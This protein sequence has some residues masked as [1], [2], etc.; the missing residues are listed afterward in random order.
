[1]PQDYQHY[2]SLF[3]DL[4]M[5]L[6]FV[7]LDLLDRNIEAVLQRGKNKQIRV[8][9]KSVRSTYILKHI[10]EYSPRFIGI[11]SYTGHE[12]VF[13]AKKGFDNL[14]VAYPVSHPQEI[15]AV[16]E[17]IQ[18]GSNIYLM[19][20]SQEHVNRIQL[21][22]KE[23]G[24]E[25][26]VCMDVDM[27]T[28]HFG[29][30]FG[31]YRSPIRSVEQA[32]E[33]ADYISKQSSVVLKGV[34]GYEAQIAGVPDKT[35]SFGA[36][37][38][39]L[40]RYLKKKSLKTVR[41]RR[42]EVVN[43]LEQRGWELEFVNGGGTGSVELTAEEDVITEVTAGSAFYSPRLF[44]YYDNFKHSPAAG[45]ALEITRIPE[46]SVY[47]CRGGGY[48]ASGSISPEKSPIPYLPEGA[49][50]VKNEGAGEVQTPVV[51]KGNIDLRIGDPI[52]FR[53]AKAGE[54]CEH[55]K[56]LYIIKNEKIIE[57]SPTYRGE[58]QLF[59]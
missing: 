32:I 47:T 35:P 18:T 9:S 55:F 34:M 17:Q 33:L 50:L 13:L 4:E 41:K 46:P 24:I 42:A 21:I 36:V 8:A 16:S 25:V 53:H 11:M 30:H 2:R 26:P 43:A 58:G 49:K 27:S 14:L 40:V 12:A 56:Y 37:K 6:A 7:D 1:M 48:I 59:L 44:D 23:M 3:R 19:V 39:A 51:Y 10:L 54:L 20:D 22:S 57:T 29:M 15:R 45:F 5:P 31:V 38:N 28:K 52:I